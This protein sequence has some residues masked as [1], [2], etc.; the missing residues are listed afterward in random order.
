MKLVKATYVK[1]NKSTWKP[2]SETYK[3]FRDWKR[4]FTMTKKT[5][6]VKM[7]SCK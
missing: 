3:S 2:A 4:G 7:P 5:Y 1:A 6:S